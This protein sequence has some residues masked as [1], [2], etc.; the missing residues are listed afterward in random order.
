M[1][2]YRKNLQFY[3]FGPTFRKWITSFYIEI[4]SY[5]INNGHLSECFLLERSD[6]EILY[7]P[8][9][10]P[11]CW[12]VLV[13]NDPQVSSVTINEFEYLPSQYADD[14]ALILG[15]GKN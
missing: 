5:V 10:S 3:G 14:S 8:T 13:K 2:F 7:L 6:N 15:D 12:N 4:S 9:F 1:A 11:L